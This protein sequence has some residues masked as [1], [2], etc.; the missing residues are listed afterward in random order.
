MSALTHA[1]REVLRPVLR[2]YAKWL[3]A[4][5]G[6]VFEAVE[7]IV[8]AREQAAREQVL[9]QVEA[10]FKELQPDSEVSSPEDVGFYDGVQHARR[11][12]RALVASVREG[13]ER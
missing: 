8:A 10:L 13:A 6:P 1:E 7:S 3:N 11:A 12:L 5:D 9:A 2:R 4:H